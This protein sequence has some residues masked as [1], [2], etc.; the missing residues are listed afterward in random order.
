MAITEIQRLQERVHTLEQLLD[1]HERTA[2]EQAA[3]LEEAHAAMQQRAVERNRELLAALGKLTQQEEAFRMLFE[4]APVAYHEIDCFGVILRVNR[5]EC[6]LLGYPSEEMVGRPIWEFVAPSDR[7]VSRAATLA[8]LSAVQ[9]LTPSRRKYLTSRN[10][11][12]VLE[13]HESY[14]LDCEGKIQGI[15]TALI[16]ITAR[17][18]AERELQSAKEAAEAAS[19][20][21]SEFLANMSHEI[22]TPMNAVIGLTDLAMAAASPG[23]VEYLALVKESAESLLTIINDIL[24]F[25]KIEAGKLVIEEIPFELRETIETTVKTMESRAREKGLALTV[26]MAPEVPGAVRGDRCRFRQVLVN[27]IS[28]AIKFTHVGRVEIWVKAEETGDTVRVEVAVRDT[29]I[30]M[31]AEQK[32]RIFDAFEQADNSMS[33]RFGGTGLGLAISSNLAT[34]MGGRIRVESTPGMGSTFSFECALKPYVG[35]IAEHAPNRV[36][37]MAPLNVLL[38]EDSRVNQRVACEML[39]RAGHQVA[40]AGDGFQ[41][42]ALAGQQSFDLILMD[43]HMPGMDGLAATREIRSR[44]PGGGPKIVAMTACAMAADRE[45]CLEAG[46]D[47]YVSKPVTMEALV[48]EMCRVVTAAV[49]QAV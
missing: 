21:K 40:V 27:L 37:A 35:R 17:V 23:Q 30:G 7:D 36:D 5:A 18:R 26:S 45:R 49:P 9:P 4:E 39:Q 32:R 16:D 3:R 10:A 44:L 48:R 28:N 33:R 15:R 2:V 42:V 14:L 12:L 25:S 43:L 41:A 6:R 20:A 8:K 47:G 11:I 38:A 31:T 22:R 46:M 29:G 13:I 1:A 34:L 24:D 19:R